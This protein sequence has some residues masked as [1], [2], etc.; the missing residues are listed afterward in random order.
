MSLWEEP[1]TLLSGLASV[2]LELRDAAEAVVKYTC[3]GRDLN[4]LLAELQDQGR[5]IV[6][7][8]VRCFRYLSNSAG[9]VQQ[10]IMLLCGAS[11]KGWPPCQ[12][13][14]ANNRSGSSGGLAAQPTSSNTVPKIKLELHQLALASSQPL[15]LAGVAVRLT[16]W[17]M[18]RSGN[19]AAS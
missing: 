14:D 4:M 17:Q 5:Q 7:V 16:S 15:S 10:V 6:Q 9:P 8:I 3:K 1:G 18:C 13:A 2:D 12:L 19:R 11:F